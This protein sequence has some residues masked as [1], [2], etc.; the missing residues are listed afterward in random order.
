MWPQ[1]LPASTLAEFQAALSK[2]L[3][4]GETAER[5]ACSYSNTFRLRGKRI[6]NG[7]W[8]LGQLRAR[9]PEACPWDQV[10]DLT[11]LPEALRDEM[12]DWLLDHAQDGLSPSSAK[13]F[14]SAVLYYR[15]ITL[16]E[17]REGLPQEGPFCFFALLDAW[18]DAAGDARRPDKSAFW[19][20]KLLR[21]SP[22]E[23]RLD[24]PLSGAKTP[25]RLGGSLSPDLCRTLRACLASAM[26]ELSAQGE[27][28]KTQFI[29]QYFTPFHAEFPTLQ[30]FVQ[31]TVLP[32]RSALGSAPPGVTRELERLMVMAR[33]RPVLDPGEAGMPGDHFA[34]KRLFLLCMFALLRSTLGGGDRDWL[35]PVGPGDS[36]ECKVLY[37]LSRIGADLTGQMVQNLALGVYGAHA[38][39]RAPADPLQWR[40]GAEPDWVHACVNNTLRTQLRDF[41]AGPQLFS[42]AMEGA[43]GESARALLILLHQMVRGRDRFQSVPEIASDL[44]AIV[45][46]LLA[47][48]DDR[49]RR[50]RL[51]QLLEP[52]PESLIKLAKRYGLTGLEESLQALEDVSQDYAGL[53]QAAAE[54]AGLDPGERLRLRR[55]AEAVH[56]RLTLGRELEAN[57]AAQAGQSAPPPAPVLSPPWREGAATDYQ[58]PYVCSAFDSVNGYGAEDIQLQLA[59]ILLR[60]GR[61]ILTAPQVADNPQI[62][63]MAWSNPHFLRLI[64][65]GALTLSLFQLNGTYY[66]SLGEYACDVLGKDSFTFSG[67]TLFQHQDPCT[68]NYLRQCMR[69]Y[70][71]AEDSA[72]RSAAAGQMPL[73]YQAELLSYGEALRLMD[74]VLLGQRYGSGEDAS[75]LK[76]FYHQAGGWRKN[77]EPPRL[78][79]AVGRHLSRLPNCGALYAFHRDLARGLGPDAIRSQIYRSLDQK[80]EAGAISPEGADEYRA[81]VDWMY[82]EVCS[83]RSTPFLEHR[84]RQKYAHLLPP[85]SR[86]GGDRSLTVTYQVRS[87]APG[88]KVISLEGIADFVRDAAVFVQ[89]EPQARSAGAIL[90]GVLR[91]DPA[92]DLGGEAGDYLEHLA[93]RVAPPGGAAGRDVVQDRSPQGPI[94]QWEHQ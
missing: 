26:G 66:H 84:I 44:D 43:A 83:A 70:L 3:G 86:A 29:Y 5:T 13:K 22:T 51:I 12:L 63:G 39:Y 92:V 6:R 7:A 19:L 1:E 55:Q 40:E 17:T 54:R 60:S 34:D 68:R 11:Q 28:T 9:W 58:R 25:F 48:Y 36:A 46:N 91:N 8:A 82:F 71:A 73:A 10:E 16:R 45:T 4:G 14:R 57:L 24:A 74:E 53:L 33:Y 21:L 81:V 69:R 64:R 47:L 76:A 88:A 79:E 72:A 35:P 52:G 62:L 2:Q 49:A 37:R 77:R 30:A 20:R 38:L 89:K 56:R 87:P 78:L 90:K 61:V 18:A 27:E 65:Y 41:T 32:N 80:A 94:S 75:T 15:R 93:V 50:V 59:S 67:Y 85:D 42:E 23:V 31:R